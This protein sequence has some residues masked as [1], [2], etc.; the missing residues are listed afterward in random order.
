VIL[1]ALVARREQLRAGEGAQA[2]RMIG[3]RFS[4]EAMSLRAF[5]DHSRL[6][7]TWIDV[8]EDP[9]GARN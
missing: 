7:Y 5:A 9:N 8:E 6:P 2:I 1:A 3:S 4:A